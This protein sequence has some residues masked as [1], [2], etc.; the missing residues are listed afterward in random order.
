MISLMMKMSAK[1]LEEKLSKL[2]R[3]DYKKYKK[4]GDYS[5]HQNKNKD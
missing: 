2:K 3:R 4:K 1:N 5:Y